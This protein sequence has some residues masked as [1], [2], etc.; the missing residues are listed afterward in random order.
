M[1]QARDEA[2]K[3]ERARSVGAGRADASSSLKMAKVAGPEDARRSREAWRRIVE[4]DPDGK[5]AD[6][7]RVRVI[8]AGLEAYRLGG[9]EADRLQA[10]RD[11]DAYLARAD[12]A[13]ADRVRA[14]VRRLRDGRR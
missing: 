11:A 14:I 6:A 8:E 7:A 5:G 4:S 3:D 1:A 12:A 2:K 10:Q 9:D 13:Q